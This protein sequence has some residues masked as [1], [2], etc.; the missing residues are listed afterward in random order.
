MHIPLWKLGGLLMLTILFADWN[1]PPW[2]VGFVAPVNIC[3]PFVVG[4]T[5]AGALLDMGMANQ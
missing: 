1:V 4:L 5:V 2:T 3:G